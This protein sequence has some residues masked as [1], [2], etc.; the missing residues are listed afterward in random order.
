MKEPWIFDSAP[1]DS[2][3]IWWRVVCKAKQFDIARQGTASCA[4]L[5][6]SLCL[7]FFSL[8]PA[9]GFTQ[10]GDYGFGLP[11]LG[12]VAKLGKSRDADDRQLALM[13]ALGVS[14]VIWTPGEWAGNEKTPGNY[15]L[16][17]EVKYVIARIASARMQ[18]VVLL[19]RKNA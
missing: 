19:F 13:R 14:V 16:T 3:V 17:P 9:P 12:M 5:A 4:I 2:A 1:R 8:W 7:V 15:A 10:P 6:A 11:R 18:M